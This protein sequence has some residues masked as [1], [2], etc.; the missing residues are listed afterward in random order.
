[1]RAGRDAGTN[2][3]FFSGNEVYWKSRWEK[4]QDG[5][6]TP[7]RTLVCYKDTWANA[8][9]D[10]VTPTATWRDPRFGDLGHGPENALTGTLYKANSVDLAITVNDAEGKLR[11]WR[12]TALASLSQR[13][14]RDAGTAHGRLRVQRGP[15]TTASGPTG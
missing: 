7:N 12:N 13:R 6:D 2:L 11:L 14:N 9:I 8:R 15:S 4:S 1:M 5:T 10:P 3:A